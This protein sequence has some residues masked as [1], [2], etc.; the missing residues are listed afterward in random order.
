[1]AHSME[2][3]QRADGKWAWRIKSGDDI[4]ATDGGQGYENESDCLAGLFGNFFDEWDE[5]FLDL[6]AQWQATKGSGYD[7]PPEAQEGAPVHIRTAP[8]TPAEQAEADD[9]VLENR[10]VTDAAADH[11]TP[12]RDLDA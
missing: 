5:S 6:Y 11:H 12:T 3:Y 8:P 10:V 4:A 7:V 9:A 1:M 2:T